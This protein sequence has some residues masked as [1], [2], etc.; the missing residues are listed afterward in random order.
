MFSSLLIRK[1]RP[2]PPS[3]PGASPVA[4]SPI[5]LWWAHYGWSLCAGGYTLLADDP[6]S[7]R[8]RS[9]RANGVNLGGS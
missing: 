5:T 4:A 2:R 7:P 1:F 9:T 8:R 6:P 3:E